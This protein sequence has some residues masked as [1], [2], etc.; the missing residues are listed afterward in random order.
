M[1]ITPN[2]NFIQRNTTKLQVRHV[3]GAHTELELSDGGQH[4]CWWNI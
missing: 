2:C 3:G 1:E 4:V